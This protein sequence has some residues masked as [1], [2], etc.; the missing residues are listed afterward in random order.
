ME[1][2]ISY[3]TIFFRSLKIKNNIFRV[4]L[5]YGRSGLDKEYEKWI[6]SEK[7][8][9]EFLR[10]KNNQLQLLLTIII[11]YLKDIELFDECGL[12]FVG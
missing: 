8:L 6:K 11:N 5:R 7:S 1:R 10:V 12:C 9:N 4:N 3:R 2:F